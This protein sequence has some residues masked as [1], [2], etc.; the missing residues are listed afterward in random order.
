MVEID[1][2][3][4]EKHSWEG[5]LQS[6]KKYMERLLAKSE[7]K[8]IRRIEKVNQG[9][10]EAEARDATQEREMKLILEKNVESMHRQIEALS[11]KQDAQYRELRERQEERFE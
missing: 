7:K 3:M 11:A 8:V 4:N 2:N 9:V 6:I 10:I 5:Q 1:D